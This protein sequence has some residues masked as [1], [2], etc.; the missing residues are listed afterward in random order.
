MPDEKNFSMQR[1]PVIMTFN[2]PGGYGLTMTPLEEQIIEEYKAGL[3]GE[4][5]AEQIVET[6]V[7]GFGAEKMPSADSIASLI[8]DHT[9]DSV[10]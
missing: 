10:A 3:I 2:R 4:G 5:I 7:D 9:G 6:L 8:K 1:N